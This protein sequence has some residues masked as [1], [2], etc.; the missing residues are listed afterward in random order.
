MTTIKTPLQ[1]KALAPKS[2][3]SEAVASP[4]QNDAKKHKH[5]L[6]LLIPIRDRFFDNLW[7]DK[8]IVT[9]Q[10][11]PNTNF[12]LR[13]PRNEG[14]AFSSKHF[15]ETLDE[16][17][18][19]PRLS[20]HPS[21]EGTYAEMIHRMFTSSNASEPVPADA[22]LSAKAQGQPR[23]DEAT[24]Q[25]FMLPMGYFVIHVTLATGEVRTD[26]RTNL[27]GLVKYLNNYCLS[28]LSKQQEKFIE[29][30]EVV[31][32]TLV[33]IS[34]AVFSSKFSLVQAVDKEQLP[35][36]KLC[37][38]LETLKTKSP[39]MVVNKAL[40]AESD[41]I[42]ELVYVIQLPSCPIVIPAKQEN[43]TRCIFQ[44]IHH[45]LAAFG[46][47][48]IVI[49][50]ILR[51]E[52]GKR[53]PESFRYILMP[54]DLTS[55]GGK[56]VYHKSV[57]AET[58]LIDPAIFSYPLMHG[59]S[60]SEPS[61]DDMLRTLAGFFYTYGY[62]LAPPEN[63]AQPRSA[64]PSSPARQ[65]HPGKKYYATSGSQPADNGEGRAV[66]QGRGRGQ[67]RGNNRGRGRN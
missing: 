12:N 14:F 2:K 48:T 29:T 17:F 41:V 66:Y 10:E 4:V 55:T 49:K 58:S 21:S 63:L 11:S 40:Y 22:S 15:S 39:Q 26:I 57:S 28:P 53:F 54:R 16:S 64:R 33:K 9:M 42:K 52:G 60:R 62:R 7:I 61:Q 37:E 47:N 20:Q 27:P 5:S 13:I 44:A 35:S 65:E 45:H 46:S 43:R 18:T 31:D 36:G 51:E 6:Q 32:K 50:N 1:Q 25:T 34:N 24:S 59:F 3:A 19:Q 23:L 30:E 8:A 67:G 38:L 56:I